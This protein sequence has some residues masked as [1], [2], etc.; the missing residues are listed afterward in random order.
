MPSP[1]HAWRVAELVGEPNRVELGRSL[2]HVVH[3]ADER[4]LPTASPLARASVRACRAELLELAS[5]L[6]HT[7][8]AVSARGMLRVQSLLV[9]PG[10]PLYAAGDT[11]RLRSEIERAVE[12]LRD[13]H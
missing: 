1:R 6:F 7:E 2:T 4:L 8:E 5:V 12:E 9:A 11:R 13:R 10:S 3:S